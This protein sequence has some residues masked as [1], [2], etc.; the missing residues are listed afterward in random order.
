MSWRFQRSRDGR[1]LELIEGRQSEPA[2]LP[3]GRLGHEQIAALDRAV[4]G[5]ATGVPEFGQTAGLCWARVIGAAEMMMARRC[6]PSC[7]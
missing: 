2:D 7:H 5:M 3:G 4:E 1:S 6:A